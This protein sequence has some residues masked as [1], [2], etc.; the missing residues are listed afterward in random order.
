MIK[1]EKTCFVIGSKIK[2]LPYKYDKK[3][4]MYNSFKEVMVDEL[5]KLIDTKGITKFIF[6]ADLNSSIYAFE[7][8]LNF[9]ESYPEIIIEVIKP[10]SLNLEAFNDN[11]KYKTSCLLKYS[12]NIIEINNT[13]YQNELNI[14]VKYAISRSDT[15][16]VFWDLSTGTT[17]RAISFAKRLNK[18]II[19]INTNNNKHFNYK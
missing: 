10:K 6:I 13:S 17:S 15:I 2:Y 14:S 1:N 11:N 5:S 12:N 16:L 3:C 4:F 18:N 7:E 8:L 19:C 9:R